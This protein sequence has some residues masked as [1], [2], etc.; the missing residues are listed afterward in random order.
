MIDYELY[1]KCSKPYISSLPYDLRTNDSVK[2]NERKDVVKSK[3][4]EYTGKLKSLN[5]ELDDIN[6]EYDK[7]NSDDAVKQI[8]VDRYL[9]AFHGTRENIDKSFQEYYDELERIPVLLDE[10]A[11]DVIG[12]TRS[13]FADVGYERHYDYILQYLDNIRK[14][15]DFNY[16]KF[17]NEYDKTGEPFKS[18]KFMKTLYNNMKSLKGTIR[19]IHIEFWSDNNQLII[20]PI[21]RK[22]FNLA[23]NY[24]SDIKGIYD[25]HLRWKDEYTSTNKEIRKI[26][27]R[28]N[29]LKKSQDSIGYEVVKTE[30]IISDLI[31]ELIRIDGKLE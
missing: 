22:L 14:D 1:C 13:M 4:D 6:R 31:D 20:N 17:H 27:R 26:H 2:L 18:T 23:N 16:D 5:E 28:M 24:T 19:N 25:A 29:K 15:L 7:L 12:D 9:D 8:V 3:I 21:P 30:K 11:K 10:H